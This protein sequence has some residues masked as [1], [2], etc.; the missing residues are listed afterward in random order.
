MSEL[1]F[2]TFSFLGALSAGSIG[3]LRSYL[4]RT[5]GPLGPIMFFRPF[6]LQSK[7]LLLPG[8]S[9]SGHNGSLPLWRL[10]FALPSNTTLGLDLGLGE[11]VKVRL[12][13]GMD[14]KHSEKGTKPRSYS[15]T[16]YPERKGSFDL[17]VKEYEHGC[18]SKYLAGVEVGEHVLMSKG[19]PLPASMIMQR[20]GGLRLGLIAMGI[21]ITEAVWVA[22][23]ELRK[24]EL[25]TVR[26]LYANRYFADRVML[27]ELDGLKRDYP[28]RFTLEDLVSREQHAAARHGRASAEILRAV[29][30]D[31]WAVDH[32]TVRFLCVGTKPMKQNVWDMLES[33]G[34]SQKVHALL[35]KQFFP[36]SS[37]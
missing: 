9:G 5:P 15:P 32:S 2:M 10:T 27:E 22:R 31:A 36:R 24:S 16:S 13:E 6:V 3:L 30:D 21:G 25:T 17:I 20:S 1:K 7:E 23:E 12:P 34:Y 28:D 4:M 14:C 26:L 35:V 33:N 11:H 8:S 29:F 37:H 18:C 19:W